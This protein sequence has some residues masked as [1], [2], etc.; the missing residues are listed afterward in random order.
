MSNDPW[1]GARLGSNG[2]SPLGGSY[3]AEVVNEVGKW[4]CPGFAS[5]SDR[6]AALVAWQGNGNTVSDGMCCTC[7]G[8]PYRRIGGTWRVDGDRII[9]RVANLGS[10]SGSIIGGGSTETGVTSG[11]TLTGGSTFTVYEASTWAISAEFRAG[12]NP[13]N[14][15]VAAQCTVKINGAAVGNFGISRL[16]TSVPVI[17][18]I[19]LAAATHT[20]SLR[21]D[22]V[23]GPVSWVDGIVTLT[24][25]IAE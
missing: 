11:A 4:S 18:T 19:A 13:G 2:D 16:D 23:G 21:V 14:T 17:A 25:G 15:S 7:A 12:P 22:A 20:V 3:L 10:G 1:T 8:I 9:Q 24:K 5:T 6:D